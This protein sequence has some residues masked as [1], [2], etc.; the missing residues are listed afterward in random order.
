MIKSGADLEKVLERIGINSNNYS[1][2]VPRS[3]KTNRNVKISGI[4]VAG[5]LSHKIIG[6]A[7]ASNKNIILT[8]NKL[9]RFI[10]SEILEIL[11][12]VLYK[13]D[14]FVLQWNY[15]WLLDNIQGDIIIAKIF[16]TAYEQMIKEGNGYYRLHYPTRINLKGMLQR[17]PEYLISGKLVESEIFVTKC[18]IVLHENYRDDLK[19][20]QD[21]LFITLI[22]LNELKKRLIL[23]NSQLLIEIDLT[24]FLNEISREIYF[25]IKQGEELDID[26][27]F[28]KRLNSKKIKN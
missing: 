21:E 25:L 19:M 26:L 24:D 3:Q 20:N 22:G 11:G 16:D 17:F 2:I 5:F 23:R 1:W 27:S 28:N 18:G 8:S 13:N 10:E 9:L 6:E 12:E 4:L 14:L 7:L 15:S